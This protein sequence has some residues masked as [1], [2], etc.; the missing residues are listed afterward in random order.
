MAGYAG[1]GLVG[2]GVQSMEY[3]VWS[4]WYRVWGMR[5]RKQLTP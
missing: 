4:I 5:C 3:R 2:D 1:D